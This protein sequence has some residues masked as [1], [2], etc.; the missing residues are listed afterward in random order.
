[1][2]VRE[3]PSSPGPAEEKRHAKNFINSPLWS[4]FEARTC[5]LEVALI[6]GATVRFPHASYGVINYECHAE[7]MGTTPRGLVVTERKQLYAGE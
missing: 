7:M 6:S 4:A 2:S 1:M 5:L 3:H